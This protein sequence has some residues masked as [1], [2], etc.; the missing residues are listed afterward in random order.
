MQILVARK[1][2]DHTGN[3]SARGYE[4]GLLLNDADVQRTNLLSSTL[5]NRSDGA[6]LSPSPA[7]VPQYL[8]VTCSISGKT[9]VT[10]LIKQ[11]DLE[12]V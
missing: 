10:L 4:E 11:I 5:L 9:L 3:S 8:T 7:Y 12:I 2:L 6:S 1:Q